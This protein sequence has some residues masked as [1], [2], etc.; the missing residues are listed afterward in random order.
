MLSKLKAN[1]NNYLLI[2]K[3]GSELSDCSYRSLTKVLE[4]HNN[5]DV[6][7]VDVNKVR[8]IHENYGINSAPSLLV[9]K[10][11]KFIK[12]EK[13]CNTEE[14]YKSLFESSLY[15]SSST[16]K[17]KT[18]KKVTVYSTPSCSWC[19]T[20]KRH[21]DENGI[22]YSDVDVSKDQNA[23]AEMVKKSG[24][25][26]VPQTDIAGQII[27]GFDKNRINSLLGIN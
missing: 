21:L 4:S 27:V 15:T 16:E 12:A 9:F 19:T 26:G 5:M 14:F 3:K 10:G 2:Y 1:S 23:A 20:L 11:N 8:D 13:G 17:P 24:Q 6:M 22:K 7:T 18:Q 25:Q